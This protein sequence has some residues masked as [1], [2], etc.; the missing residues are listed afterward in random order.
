MLLLK[1]IAVITHPA[2]SSAPRSHDRNSLNL[3]KPTKKRPGRAKETKG[4]GKGKEGEEVGAGVVAKH[5]H[6]SRVRK[7]RMVIVKENPQ[8]NSKG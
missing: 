6:L 8:E 3:S 4:M 1:N 2:R 7:S 5:H